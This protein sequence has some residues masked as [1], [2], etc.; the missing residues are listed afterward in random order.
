MKNIILALILIVGSF[1]CESALA[2]TKFSIFWS[3]G[4]HGDIVTHF[5][6][7]EN[8]HYQP[9]HYRHRGRGHHNSGHHNSGHHNS[10]HHNSGHHNSGHQMHWRVIQSYHDHGNHRHCSHR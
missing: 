9:R 7:S 10:G 8:R 5:G 2:G 1:G 4:H 3:I 6:I